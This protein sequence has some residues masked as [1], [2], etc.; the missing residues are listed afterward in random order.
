MAMRQC[1]PALAIKPLKRSGRSPARTSEDL[2]LPEVPT[3][4]RKRVAASLRR[5][6]SLWP[7]RPK[8]RWLSPISKGRR[9]GKGFDGRLDVGER[10]QSFGRHPLTPFLDAL[11]ETARALRARSRRSS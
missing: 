1:E 2:P 9:P 4:A 8:K 6:S 10:G 5:S 3:T 7:S 11:D